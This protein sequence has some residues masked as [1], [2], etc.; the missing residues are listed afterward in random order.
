[1]SLGAF[2]GLAF[3]FVLVDAEVLAGFKREALFLFSGFLVFWIEVVL[4]LAQ[5]EK[6]VAPR[7]EV[8]SL[9]PARITLVSGL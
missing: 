1:M 6:L 8:L 7:E 2:L 4:F 9:R 3:V 5:K